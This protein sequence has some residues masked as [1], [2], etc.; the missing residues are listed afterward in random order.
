METIVMDIHMR[1]PLLG[2]SSIMKGWRNGDWICNCGFHNYSSC[3]LCKECNASRP[4]VLFSFL[5]SKYKG[6]MY[7]FC[8]G[9]RLS[10]FVG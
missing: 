9:C 3:A 10:V 8:L 2:R 4:L 7:Q 5:V 1:M 6:L